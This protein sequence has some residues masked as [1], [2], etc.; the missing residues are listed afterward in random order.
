MLFSTSPVASN[1]SISH[2]KLLI[3]SYSLYTEY[4]TLGEGMA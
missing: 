3:V 4:G 2:H 1:F